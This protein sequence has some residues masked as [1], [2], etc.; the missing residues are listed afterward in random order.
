M[1]YIEINNDLKISRVA[2]GCMR[3]GNKSVDSIEKLIFSAIE[4]GINFFD[5]ADIY[6]KGLSEQLFGEVLKTNPNLR[7]Q[8]I[9]QS[10]CGIRPGYFDFSK[11]HI[12]NSVTESLKRL[13]T[14]YL[15]V[16]LLHR[17]DSLMEP[18]E[19]SEAFDYLY[20]KGMV[21][22]FGVSNFNVMQI[23]LLQKYLHHKIRF[24][25][26]QFNVVHSTMVDSGLNV[27]MKND[28][29]INRDDSILEYCRLKDITIQ[30]W[31]VM[32]ASWEEG[33]YIDNPNYQALNNKLDELGL[34][35]NVS[36]NTIALAWI[37][38]H[39]A[40]M[41]PII[42]TTNTYHLEDLLKVPKIILS[43]EEW[44]N[45]YCSVGKILP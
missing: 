23:E 40:K 3:I 4:G 20:S 36:K 42:G 8:M 35:Y 12:I 34:K 37:L 28:L 5:H 19:V 30:P 26:L 9:I 27:N 11:D 16:L 33:T 22:N 39:P 29:A 2:F 7:N 24:N 13:N 10:K 31:S 38:R 21:R 17:P 44:Y 41:Q 18:Y 32:Q 6:G 45:L 43:R 1:E 15:D 25:Q 14:N